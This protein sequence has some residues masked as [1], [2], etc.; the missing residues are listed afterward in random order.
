MYLGETVKID[1]ATYLI[2]GVMRDVPSRSH[3]EFDM[4][5]SFSTIE[6]INPDTDGAFFAW[7]NIYMNYIYLSL[8]ESND[9]NSVQQ[10]IDKLCQ[11]GKCKPER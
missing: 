1:T 10:S 5:A 2:T 8:P 6:K 4:L 11:R 3:L 7:N 9:V